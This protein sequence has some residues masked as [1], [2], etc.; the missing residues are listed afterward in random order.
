V[1]SSRLR[2]AATFAGRSTQPPPVP[3]RGRCGEPVAVGVVVVLDGEM[4]VL[5]K[6]FGYASS[7][8]RDPD[9]DVVACRLP[10]VS[11]LAELDAFYTEHRR[12]GDLDA[13]SKCS[14]GRPKEVG[15]CPARPR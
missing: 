10:A 13:V 9:L 1:S 14:A 4:A 12:A 15:P 5:D 2:P 8:L 11:L 7:G 6:Q 3:R